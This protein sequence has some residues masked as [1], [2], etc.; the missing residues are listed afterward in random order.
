MPDETFIRQEL[1]A[2][3]RPSASRGNPQG[4]TDSAPDPSVLKAGQIPDETF[5]RQEF[6]RRV[7]ARRLA[8]GNPQ[9]VAD[10]APDPSVLKLSPMPEE[11]PF[12]KRARNAPGG[13]RSLW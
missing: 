6:P 8:C 13:S 3:G 10:P 12:T 7:A 1:P 9:E 4:I 5:I 2:C 11:S